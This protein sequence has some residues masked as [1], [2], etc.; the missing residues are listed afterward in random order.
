[1]VEAKDI[2]ALK[3]AVKFESI[4]LARLPDGQIHDLPG[5]TIVRL[6][7]PDTFTG[8]YFQAVYDPKGILLR[9]DIAREDA[10]VKTMTKEAFQKNAPL[11]PLNKIAGAKSLTMGCFYE[12]SDPRFE[13][14][15]YSVDSEPYLNL[16]NARSN[17]F[18]KGEYINNVNTNS[19]RDCFYHYLAGKSED[20]MRDGQNS[21]GHFWWMWNWWRRYGAVNAFRGNW[22]IRNG[23]GSWENSNQILI[24]RSL[25]SYDTTQGPPPFK[26]CEEVGDTIMVPHGTEQTY[27][28]N[29]FND[30]EKCNIAFIATHGGRIHNIFQIKQ[31]PE[32]WIVLPPVGS[33]Y[34]TNIAL[35]NGSLRHLFFD[36]CGAFTYRKEPQNACLIDTWIRK[37]HVN[38]LRTASGYDGVTGLRDR[39]GW[40]FF[41]YYNKY[42]SIS[43]SWVFAGLDED[44]GNCPVTVSYGETINDSLE[45]LLK[46]RF[47]DQ[48]AGRKFAAFSIW[49]GIPAN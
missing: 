42:E 10:P 30:L 23:Q 31:R 26:K 45:T 34:P 18:R 14:S 28:Q 16:V 15:V 46:G 47:N 3:L 27:G 37:L 39:S 29:F 44:F 48:R 1:M 17:P 2:P 25:G 8:S 33:S 4:L 43:D 38:G 5:R 6:G 35:G 19:A 7:Y 13:A 41:G 20:D 32:V 49:Y 36:S 12:P 9:I 24:H 11:P 21:Q 22:I 40:R